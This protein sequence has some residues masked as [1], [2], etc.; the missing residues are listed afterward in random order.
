MLTCKYW[1]HYTSL[2]M[3]TKQQ[4]SSI[5]CSYSFC[6]MNFPFGSEISCWLINRVFSKQI[7]MTVRSSCREMT[8]QELE[9][10]SV[11]LF[12]LPGLCCHEVAQHN[13]FLLPFMQLKKGYLNVSGKGQSW[14]EAQ[15]E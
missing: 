4:H 15:A 9:S 12:Y 5:V 7:P 8:D 1:G 2:E 6:S 14:Q 11:P 3:C 13:T 10:E